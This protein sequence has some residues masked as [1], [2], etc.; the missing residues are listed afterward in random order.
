M[1][2]QAA[3]LKQGLFY[4]E[5][6]RKVFTH[7]KKGYIFKDILIWNSP[8]G[9]WEKPQITS[10]RL[11]PLTRLELSTSRI[12]SLMKDEGQSTAWSRPLR[13]LQGA[14]LGGV[15]E[16]NTQCPYCSTHSTSLTDFV[17]LRLCVTHRYTGLCH[18]FIII[19]NYPHTFLVL[20]TKCN[21][22]SKSSSFCRN[23]NIHYR[24]HR[25]FSMYPV[26]RLQ[27]QTI[28]CKI[29]FNNIL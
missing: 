9:G 21:P 1:L 7:A 15:L 26:L 24:V 25:I 3:G 6:D 11:V 8:V 16:D 14:I 4:V 13:S 10:E 27:I 22:I 28:N 23:L 29:F 20:F 12:Q 17:I 19:T 2:P 18:W 5:W